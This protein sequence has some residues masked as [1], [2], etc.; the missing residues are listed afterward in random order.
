MTKITLSDV[1]K[2]YLKVGAYLLV[3][4]ALGFVLATYV[5]K[6]ENLTII[7]T[8]VI[9]FLLLILKTEIDKEGIVRA[10]ENK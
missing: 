4:G 5:A 9:N 6:D 1:V 7:F 10:L 8:P 2:K 3:S